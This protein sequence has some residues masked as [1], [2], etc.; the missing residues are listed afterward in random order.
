MSFYDKNIIVT[1]F[2]MLWEND[3]WLDMV[4]AYGFFLFQLWLFLIVRISNCLSF[5]SSNLGKVKSY[6][7]I[8]H[9]NSF[10]P[11]LERYGFYT[12]FHS[13]IKEKK[14]NVRRKYL[15]Q[16]YKN[17]KKAFSKMEIFSFLKIYISSEWIVFYHRTF[18]RYDIEK[19]Y[20]IHEFIFPSKIRASKQ[21]IRIS[22]YATS[23]H[24]Y[25]TWKTVSIDWPI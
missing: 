10:L 13:L 15:P 20:F 1:L 22:V 17:I 4:S 14:L 8:N 24:A 3:G 9:E 16:E 23:Q 5:F 2:W 25:I 7:F 11:S 19:I 21:K 18:L 12:Y 6:L